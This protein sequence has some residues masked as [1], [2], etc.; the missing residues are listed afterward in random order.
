MILGE[1]FEE[2]EEGDDPDRLFFGIKKIGL[3]PQAN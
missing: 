1:Y 2:T 3:R